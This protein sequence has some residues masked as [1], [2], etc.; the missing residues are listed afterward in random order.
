MIS[1]FGIAPS[2][3]ATYLGG[4][5]VQINQ[6]KSAELMHLVRN[7]FGCFLI[8]MNCLVTVKTKFMC[9]SAQLR[10]NSVFGSHF[11]DPLFD[12]PRVDVRGES[13][14]AQLHSF[15]IHGTRCIEMPGSPRSRCLFE[16]PLDIWR[17]VVGRLFLGRLWEKIEKSEMKRR[18]ENVASMFRR[19]RPGSA[20][21]NCGHRPFAYLA[22]ATDG[23]GRIV[24]V[25]APKLTYYRKS[26]V[27]DA[28]VWAVVNHYC[29]NYRLASKKVIVA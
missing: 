18:F 22:R 11:V 21:N 14:Q 2:L 3:R 9:P 19:I 4:E 28:T 23:N 17:N 12:F 15:S 16:R 1:S 10:R 29:H 26:A 13:L 25:V 20:P 27:A 7:F 8:P 6:Q 24:L 5:R